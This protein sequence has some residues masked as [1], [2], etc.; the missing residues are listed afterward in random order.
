MPTERGASSSG[1]GIKI[2]IPEVFVGLCQ[3]Y[4][5]KIF[6]GGRGAAKSW[7]FARC[8]LVLSLTKTIRVLC[9][10]EYQNSIAESV[11]RLLVNQIYTLGL[12]A[13]FHITAQ[14]ITSQN[15]SEFIFRGLARNSAAIKSLEGVD[16]A[17]LEEAQRVS[18]RSLE[19]LVP[20]IRKPGS[21]LWFSYNPDYKASPMEQLRNRLAEQKKFLIRKVGWQ[22]NPWFPDVL[23]QERQAL[24]QADPLAYE[25]VWEGGYIEHDESIIFAG[26]I[27]EQAF[28]EPME[29]TSFFYGADWGF[30]RDPTVLVRCFVQRGTLFVTH[31][32]FGYGIALN[33]IP[34]LFA[35]VTESQH[36]RIYADSSRPETISYLVREFGLRIKAAP[37]WPGSVHDGIAYLKSF[38]TIVV[39]PRCRQLLTELRLYSYRVDPATWQVL[40]E[41]EDAHNHGIDALRYALVECI[42]ARAVP[43]FDEADVQEAAAGFL[44]LLG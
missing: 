21:E 15:G 18:A 4:R 31:A 26:H 17:W 33:A 43:R 2:P 8:L 6:Y 11:H 39:H 23:E 29:G 22:D 28:E 40:P 7:A 24:K 36:A 35:Q 5:Y 34:A 12:E 32:V 20:T 16:I 3:P 1:K 9:L 19:I 13:F 30:A 25:H 44:P 41:V 27:E 10:R 37:K 14:S 38:K 42:R